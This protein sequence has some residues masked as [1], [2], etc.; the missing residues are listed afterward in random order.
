MTGTVCPMELNMFTLLSF[1]AMAANPDAERRERG[2]G[3]E[4]SEPGGRA[5][6]TVQVILA[7]GLPS[8]GSPAYPGRSLPKSE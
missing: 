7:A 1:P 4:V 5:V 6:C 8:V 2:G 3:S